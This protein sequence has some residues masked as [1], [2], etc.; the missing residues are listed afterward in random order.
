MRTPS[1]TKKTQSPTPK[2]DD[3]VRL[4]GSRTRRDER[5]GPPRSKARAQVEIVLKEY[6]GS[7][8][9]ERDVEE[10]VRGWLSE[11]DV[12]AA[13]GNTKDALQLR[14]KLLRDIHSSQ[15][16][17][18]EGLLDT[19]SKQLEKLK[20]HATRDQQG[21]VNELENQVAGT[22]RLVQQDIE[23]GRSLTAGIQKIQELVQEGE[24][25]GGRMT[26]MVERLAR[27]E[28][29]LFEEMPNRLRSAFPNRRVKDPPPPPPTDL[30]LAADEYM[31]KAGQCRNAREVERGEGYLNELD[32]LLL[33]ATGDERGERRPPPRDREEPPPREGV[34]PSRVPK[35]VPKALTTGTES[36][37][38]VTDHE[39]FQRF[40]VNFN[41][42]KEKPT[43]DPEWVVAVE[44]QLQLLTTGAKKDNLREAG[45]VL[46]ALYDQL[47][48]K[49]E[50]AYELAR[51][52]PPRTEPEVERPREVA[53]ELTGAF[54]IRYQALKQLL[55][56]YRQKP[57]LD[58]AFAE[59]MAEKL[60]EFTKLAR[61]AGTEQGER[62]NLGLKVI[63]LGG[64]IEG[65]F[66]DQEMVD[67]RLK[68]R[69]DRCGI[70][71]ARQ[72]R[73]LQL[74][75]KSPK[76]DPAFVKDNTVKLVQA[77]KHKNALEAEAA[78]RLIL[79]VTHAIEEL[80]DEDE[81]VEVLSPR[82]RKER[83]QRRA[84]AKGEA[85]VNI[86]LLLVGEV[87]SP[88]IRT[89]M[90]EHL[91][92]V[93]GEITA[94]KG[95]RWWED[96][97]FIKDEGE[98]REKFKALAGVLKAVYDRRQQLGDAI[99]SNPNFR[100]PQGV[101]E[102]E[103]AKQRRLEAVQM[104]QQ[105]LSTMF[106]HLPEAFRKERNP[107][108]RLRTLEQVANK[109]V[110]ERRGLIVTA[111]TVPPETQRS[112][113]EVFV[114]AIGEGSLKP[115]E[116]AQ[117]YFDVP[118]KP[119]SPENMRALNR[120]MEQV[121]ARA[122]KIHDL[123]GSTQDV[124][125]SLSHIPEEF[126]PP[127]FI[128]ELQA[129][130][131]T[132]R[133]MAEERVTDLFA[134][135]KKMTGFEVFNTVAG[136]VS[137]LSDVQSLAGLSGDLILAVEQS[138]KF[139]ELKGQGL[140]PEEIV[141]DPSY[142]ALFSPTAGPVIEGTHEQLGNDFRAVI[143]GMKEIAKGSEPIT[144]ALKND[145][146][147]S[148]SKDDI[149]NIVGKLAALTSKLRRI[150]AIS[151]AGD[152]G[153]MFAGQICP[154]LGAGAGCIELF[155][156][157]K[158]LMEIAKERGIAQKELEQ[159]D[160]KYFTGEYSDKAMLYALNNE[161]QARELQKH[162]K[163]TEFAGKVI[164]TAGRVAQAT[165]T[166]IVNPFVVAGG[167]ALRIVGRTLEMG[168]K[169]VFSGIEWNIAR[170]A[171]KMLEEAQAGNPVARV[172][173]FKHCGLY[174]KMYICI[175]AQKGDQVAVEFIVN[176]G[177]DEEALQK[178]AIALK[179][180]REA[181]LG[182][183]DQKDESKNT[184]LGGVLVENL[185]HKD[186]RKVV[187]GK[188][189]PKAPNPKGP[190]YVPGV[191]PVPGNTDPSRELWDQNKADAV[192]R[193]ALYNANSG[194][195]SALADMNQARAEVIR[196][197]QQA[198]NTPALR[199]SRRDAIAKALTASQK[200]SD[201]LLAYTPY[202]NDG[203]LHL[204]FAEYQSA[205]R[206][207][208]GTDMT[209]L[210]NRLYAPDVQGKTNNWKTLEREEYEGHNDDT[211]PTPGAILTSDSWKANWQRAVEQCMLPKDD[212]GVEKAI[213][214]FESA[215]L[216]LIRQE[217]AQ[218]PAPAKLRAARLAASK[219]LQALAA[220]LNR[221]RQQVGEFPP[222]MTWIDGLLDATVS[223]A[224]TINGQLL[225]TGWAGKPGNDVDPLG[226]GVW[227]GAFDSA[228]NQGLLANKDHGL[229]AAL[230]EYRAAQ[231][232]LA[233]L[234]D[235]QDQEKAK[236]RSDILQKIRAVAKAADEIA[237]E[238]VE[239]HP[240][241]LAFLDKLKTRAFGAAKSL[242]ETAST[243]KFTAVP[244]LGTGNWTETY[245]NAVRAGAIVANSSAHQEMANALETY[246][247]A[248]NL[249]AGELDP[250]K[251]FT[252]AHACLLTLEKVQHA[253][254]K[255]SNTPGFEHDAMQDYLRDLEQRV[256]GA[257]AEQTFQQALSGQVDD[258]AF[259]PGDFVWTHARW[260]AV[261]AD[262]VRLGLISPKSTGFG[263]S[264]D[265]AQ[266]A[267]NS[268]QS[269]TNLEK[270][271]K[272]RDA[273]L[274]AL[275]TCDKLAVV[276]LKSTKNA[277]LIAY[278]NG[279]AEQAKTLRQRVSEGV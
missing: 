166:T 146:W 126:W 216:V 141:K 142:Q 193:G 30:E 64:Q 162:K 239:T 254:L 143:E 73:A 105:F 63:E 62:E 145:D 208:I 28:H 147:S 206:G 87:L 124:E 185:I 161:V 83:E 242:R 49:A 85:Q 123:G 263:K 24:R 97:D 153:A 151:S 256:D 104:A 159:V 241:V 75:L 271:L 5:T 34:Q 135:P 93:S 235:T 249:Y 42:Y 211:L 225:S 59:R 58:R 72:T 36:P 278:F 4:L 16:H 74:L 244:G 195:G 164:G 237:L 21:A 172:E 275:D 224:Q 60:Q 152:A 37:V 45:Q 111:K 17:F 160:L 61:K 267:V 19:A 169:V 116:M 11:I 243:I 158:K 252:K 204:E 175:A 80:D 157:A 125:D 240:D 44:E 77:Q 272:K 108:E 165:G 110:E 48:I 154:W 128:D 184:N 54:G 189:T 79:E 163:N 218:A 238:N 199:K 220:A 71:I 264:L 174:A 115:A 51:S 149:L 138:E 137:F 234:K 40:V 22:G 113:R 117:F 219:Q 182:K 194:I 270:K 255:T 245:T 98:R 41:T 259:A 102:T 268:W 186:A 136:T 122:Y 261:K 23:A 8:A 202:S 200:A 78:E 118:V 6:L 91:R 20:K 88:A 33:I 192:R 65:A 94:F 3:F 232:K 90:E 217:N 230:R 134:D 222:L 177:I 13:E 210:N 121:I 253:I 176:R 29:R 190:K 251:R 10:R 140:T 18:L 7:P 228:K 2:Q 227:E 112:E 66:I 250:A 214:D 181:L 205:L 25:L 260:K 167:A 148:I 31:R 262:A 178:R 139:L 84:A 27:F 68:Q 246:G 38:D 277:K 223:E 179:V 103:L 265:A 43:A 114:Q 50:E 52:L 191:W 107:V 155:L 266:S 92:A 32:Q 119:I 99:S 198:G 132:E 213:K 247:K 187:A 106:D 95:I 1:T 274:D 96:L 188:K 248:R 131:K 130:R 231:Q 273:A 170:N 183:S 196:L 46:K 269:E 215:Q 207:R 226:P 47:E 203:Q 35:L 109:S 173:I 57:V 156:N 53:P 279:Y 55:T 257:I 168:G 127:Q 26:A 229:T 209:Q 69:L 82:Q 133:E 258:R 100:P 67:L 86:K 197:L 70:E 144:K 39:F 233:T 201:L 56:E 14:D 15:R 101:E 120:T 180:V 236:T 212:Q 129:W 221:C 76:V 171:M 81:K 150:G 9:H 89:L 276:V 12:L